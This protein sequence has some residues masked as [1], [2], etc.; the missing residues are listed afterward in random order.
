MTDRFTLT[1]VFNVLDN[2]TGREYDVGLKEYKEVCILLNELDNVAERN[3][4]LFDIANS[5]VVEVQRILDK[6]EIESL[7]KLDQ[8]L[9]E[10]RVW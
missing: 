4:R 9:M 6:Y 5:I 10:Q 2:R 1:P 3:E 7:E 8:V